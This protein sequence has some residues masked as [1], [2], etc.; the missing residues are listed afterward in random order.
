MNKIGVIT[1][2]YTSDMD[3]LACAVAYA[4]L[5][6]LEGKDA[7]VYITEELNSSVTEEI[8]TWGFK[9]EKEPKQEDLKSMQYVIVD[10]T[11]PHTFPKFVEEDKIIEIYD[12]HNGYEEMWKKRIGDKAKIEMIG[13][14]A[15]MI[16]EEYKKRGYAEKISQLSAKLL[17]AAIISNTLNFKATITSPRDAQAFKEISPIADL[18]KDW[19]DKYFV[20]QEQFIYSNPREAIINDVKI[21]EFPNLGTKITIGQVELWN[22]RKFVMDYKPLIREVLDNFDHRQWFFNA[23]CI[24][25]GKNYIYTEND[26]IKKLLTDNFSVVF[27]DGVGETNKLIERKEFVKGILTL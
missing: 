9:Y 25:K 11:D 12:H 10:T 22:S 7:E 5:L 27:E 15:T 16:W 3:S 23:P 14:C 1:A 13:A 6:N 17:Y 4:E 20:D 24:S 8:K 26:D 2:R 21:I 19:I 18:P